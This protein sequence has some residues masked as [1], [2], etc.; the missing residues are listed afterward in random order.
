MFMRFNTSKFVSFNPDYETQA[1][2]TQMWQNKIR[3][4]KTTEVPYAYTPSE[5]DP[6]VLVPDPEM[7]RWVEDAMDSLDQGHSGRRV[8]AWLVEKL[9]KKFRTK[10]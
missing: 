7:V 10:E 9:I 6:L 5:D 2:S 4:N 3:P 1:R 8:A